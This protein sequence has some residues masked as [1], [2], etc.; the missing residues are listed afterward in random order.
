MTWLEKNSQTSNWKLRPSVQM[1][2]RKVVWRALLQFALLHPSYAHSPSSKKS[3]GIPEGEKKVEKGS[4]EVPVKWWLQPRQEPIAGDA[5]TSNSNPTFNRL[6]KLPVSDSSPDALLQ[7][8]GQTE[9]A[10]RL[11]KL[12]DSAYQQGWGH[13]LSLAGE[14]LGIRWGV[15]DL[16]VLRDPVLERRIELLH[17]VRCILG[18]AVESAIL[19]DRLE[20][21]QEHLKG[22]TSNRPSQDGLRQWEVE[23]V[24]LFDQQTGSG[25]NIAVVVSPV[26]P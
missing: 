21:I 17:T 4:A 20:W 1:A 13:F 12:P 22:P 14:K 25:R 15:E 23:L 11:G 7:G 9:T 19:L 24:N 26:I 6:P 8:S 2:S 10:I 16:D 5:H 3:T 18:S